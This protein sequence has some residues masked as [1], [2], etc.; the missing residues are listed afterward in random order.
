MVLDE[1]GIGISVA[2][3]DQ[4]APSLW[5]DGTNYLVAW[6]D[7]RSGSSDLYGARVSPGGVVL[8]QQGIAI[9]TAPERQGSPAV[10]HV[11]ASFLVVWEDTRGD[12]FYTDI[13]GARLSS[14]GE[15]LDPNGIAISTA[16]YDQSFAAVVGSATNY[17]AVWEDRRNDDWAGELD[18]FGSRLSSDGEVLDQAGI[19][20]ATAAST[21]L[22]EQIAWDGTNFFLVWTDYRPY[23]QHHIYGA[24]VSP[25]GELLDGTGIPIAAADS[26]HPAV[27]WNGSSYLVV[28]DDWRNQPD[29]YVDVYGARVT[30]EGAVLDPNGILI[31]DGPGYQGSAAVASRGDRFL[32]AWSG[33]G[34]VLGARVAGDGTVLDPGGF[35]ISADPDHSEGSPASCRRRGFLSRCLERRAE[36]LLR[37]L[38]RPRRRRRGRTRSV[39]NRDLHGTGSAAFRL[40]R[41]EWSE[42][43]RHLVGLAGSP[44]WRSGHLR[45][46]GDRGR[47]RSRSFRDSGLRTARVP[48]LVG[49]LEWEQLSRRLERT[50]G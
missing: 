16:L 41:F 29:G 26:D 47:R 45:K 9:S 21:Q 50:P 22:D 6:E 5:S 12:G 11:G 30:A 20:T 1:A 4:L 40:H 24:R 34:D 13:Y 32:V 7:Q 28:W 35:V 39:R 3:N 33:G 38:R 8:D 14:D 36:R 2:A 15:V 49:R 44:K 17:L 46:Q 31:A 19:A 37:R 25:S 42:L 23:G 10:A 43:P 18:V 27:A 48:D